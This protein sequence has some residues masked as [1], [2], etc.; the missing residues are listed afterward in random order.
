MK[1]TKLLLPLVVVAGV[2][3]ASWASRPGIH[4]DASGQT[5]VFRPLVAAGEA[6][7]RVTGPQGYALEH[8]FA[9]GETPALNLSHAG[10]LRDG[11]Y[12]YEITLA[13]VER[14]ERDSAEDER[15]PEA[16]LVQAGSFRV[17]S[18]AVLLPA[19]L[20]A[21]RGQRSAPP[22][23][24]DYVIADDLIVQLSACVGFDCVNGEVFGFDTLRLKE[25]NL[26]I[27]FEDTSAAGYPS[28]D[29]QLT[30][31]DS[32][33][34]GANR[35]SIEDVTAATNPFT[36]EGAAANNSI[37]VDS[38]G[39]VGFRTATPVLDLHVNTSDTPALRFEQNNSGGYAAQTWD[40]AGNEANFFVRDVTGG[41]RLS[42]RIR[43]GAP[44]SSLDIAADGKV[45]V[46]TGSPSARLHVASNNSDTTSARAFIQETSGTAGSRNML[47]IANNGASTFRFDNT[48]T[49]Q[50]WGFGAL[51]GGNFFIAATP[52]TGLAMTLTSAGNMTIQGT[53][54]Q[55]SD[56]NSKSDIVEV[57]VGQVLDK[58]TA[59]PIATW[60]YRQDEAR[61][62]G[63][64]AQD[65]AAVFGLGADD[66][67]IAPGDM[68]AVALAAI[69]A[70]Q[71]Q[72]ARLAERVAALEAER[73]ARKLAPGR[74]CRATP[75]RRCLGVRFAERF[76]LTEPPA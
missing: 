5:L 47:R 75:G 40:V 62:M 32:A 52:G 44:T 20:E 30:A 65:F 36:I 16:G 29:W 56:R 58:V 63:P 13:P 43:P 69:Q 60:R 18:G 14:R 49:G 12:T 26:R 22:S 28:T 72:N 51:A 42:F 8:T 67:H 41:S 21:T 39:R 7:V 54:T 37:F 17:V 23:P 6:H 61:H 46:G 19:G 76:R 53:L 48:S 68:A 11:A 64:M 33:A 66:K 15:P 31:N 3:Q 57:D 70:L 24:N 50:N 9:A 73:T 45:G 25:N 71:T 34:G 1:L 35:F 2:A 59:L 4:V 10:A 55:S 74:R 38:T 27:K